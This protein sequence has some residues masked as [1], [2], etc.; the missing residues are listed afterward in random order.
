MCSTTVKVLEPRARRS[1]GIVETLVSPH[2]ASINAWRAGFKRPDAATVAV[3][4]ASSSP[5]GAGLK[6]E[7]AILS[8]GLGVSNTS[9][10]KI[11]ND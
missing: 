2:K 10:W 3:K 9:P 6:D 4:E 7:S 5:R 8:L 11:S 1:S